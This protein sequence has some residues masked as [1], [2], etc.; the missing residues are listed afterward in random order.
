MVTG[1]ISPQYH[2]VYDELF[3]TS[4]GKVTDTA[5]DA[6]L[7]QGLLDLDSVDQHLE[8]GNWEDPDVTKVAE[9]LFDA[10][11]DNDDSDTVTTSASTVSEGEDTSDSDDDLDSQPNEIQMRKLLLQRETV[12]TEH[13]LVV[14]V[15][16]LFLPQC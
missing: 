1:H 7:W 4:V 15:S 6:E 9:D 5:F 14:S 12:D 8:P 10:S 16:S 13:G 2:V 3:T 11:V